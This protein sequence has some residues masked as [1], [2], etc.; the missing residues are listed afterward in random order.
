M[1]FF[2]A[3]KLIA[4]GTPLT[5]TFIDDRRCCK[6]VTFR[7]VT[8]PSYDE[9]YSR[10]FNNARCKFQQT[11]SVKISS[12]GACATEKLHELRV[13][14]ILGRGSPPRRVILQDF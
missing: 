11:C 3:P 9:L 10:R 14:V 8:A 2:H 7:H 6:T 13:F 12:V 1:F 5:H 4:E